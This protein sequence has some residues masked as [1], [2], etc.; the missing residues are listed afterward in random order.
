MN[1]LLQPLPHPFPVSKERLGRGDLRIVPSL[2]VVR[3]ACKSECDNVRQKLTYVNLV[4]ILTASMWMSISLPLSP[5]FAVGG[6]HLAIALK[7]LARGGSRN[8]QLI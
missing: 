5:D 2:R 4:V 7:V 3:S 6:E 8:H 1:F